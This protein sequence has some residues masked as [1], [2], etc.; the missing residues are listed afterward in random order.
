MRKSL[1]VL[2]AAG[3]LT[4]LSGCGTS[5]GEDDASDTT[6]PAETT[7]TEAEGV[8]VEAWA[9]S[10]CGSFSTWLDEIQAASS[11]VADE[12]VP[13]DIGSAK[14]AI[15]N[16]FGTASAA[17][18]GLIED[19]EGAGAPAIDDG[20]QLVDDLVTKFEAFNDAA[21]AAQADTE[22]LASE[23]VASFQGAA[24]ELTTRFQDEVNTVADS[25]A[26]IDADYPSPEL[27][28]ALSA[29]CDF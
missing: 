19:L 22:A 13:G 27:N 3:M 7:T 10:F 2:A 24:D 23:D 25:F 15:S 21:L 17:T 29:S 20:D 8:E 28:A 9:D 5:G 12:V 16:L 6:D 1:A 14:T 26:E 4:I 18:E 11:G